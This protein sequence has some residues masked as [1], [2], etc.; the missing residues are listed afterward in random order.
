MGTCI[1]KKKTNK[2]QKSPEDPKSDEITKKTSL[3]TST[4]SVTTPTCY[5]KILTRIVLRQPVLQDLKQNKL[6]ASRMQKNYSE[7]TKNTQKIVD[8]KKNN[9]FENDKR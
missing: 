8:S 4:S 2:S 1:S 6:Y 7:N 3:R 5:S 9:A